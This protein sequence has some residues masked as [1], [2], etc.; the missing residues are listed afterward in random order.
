MLSNSRQRWA[1]IN[2]DKDLD[3]KPR[4]TNS[5][6]VNPHRKSKPKGMKTRDV[7]DADNKEVARDKDSRADKREDKKPD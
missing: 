1:Y 6:R 7:I 2:R 3:K 4:V 5:Q